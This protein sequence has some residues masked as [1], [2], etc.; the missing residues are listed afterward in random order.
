MPSSEYL[1]LLERVETEARAAA[2]T[3]VTVSAENGIRSILEA[4]PADC[5]QPTP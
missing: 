2:P 4:G 1:N 5:A 3:N